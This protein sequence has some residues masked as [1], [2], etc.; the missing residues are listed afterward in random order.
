MGQGEEGRLMKRHRWYGVIPHCC[1]C[2][3]SGVTWG[4]VKRGGFG[5]CRPPGTGSLQ[6]SKCGRK[7]QETVDG[8]CQRCYDEITN[9]V[10][11]ALEIAEQ[12]IGGL[13]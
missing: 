13:G 2:D 7:V 12:E 3:I 1:D 11:E 9:A 8:K 5:P 6:C 4:M 10:G